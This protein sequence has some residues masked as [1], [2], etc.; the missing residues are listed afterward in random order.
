MERRSQTLRRLA[1]TAALGVVGL[2]ALAPPAHARIEREA[3]VEMFEQIRDRAPWDPEERLLWSYFFT[4]DDRATVEAAAA[5]LAAQ[6]YVVVGVRRGE[7]AWLMQVQR[8]ERHTVDSLHQRNAA[9]SAFAQ[10]T[11]L[12]SYDGMDVGPAP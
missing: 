5:R 3:L 11:G 9:L 10:R 2:L 7:D 4:G 8:V 1:A 6:G 12:A